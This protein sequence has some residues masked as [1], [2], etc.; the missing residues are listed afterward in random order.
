MKADFKNVA[1]E[2]D[3]ILNKKEKNSHQFVLDLG[4]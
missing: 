1:D 3:E 4:T 2:L